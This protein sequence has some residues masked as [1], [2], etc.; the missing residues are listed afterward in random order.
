M[1]ILG[2][3]LGG[4]ILFV[5]GFFLFV[6]VYV[7][8]VNVPIGEAEFDPQA[9]ENRIQLPDGFSL[10]IFAAELP[11]ARVI[12]FTQ[13]GDL[14]VANPNLGKIMLVGRDSNNDGRSEGKRLLLEDLNGPNGLDFYQGYLYVA[15]TDAIGRVPFDHET[16]ELTGKYEHIVTGLPGG[17]RHWKKSLRF[18]PD[19]RMYVVMG[20]SCN[21][22]I[23]KDQR[24]A[25][26]T[27]YLADGSDEQIFA[28]GL[29]NSP[30]FD[31]SPVDGHLYAADNGTDMLGDDY[32]PCELNKVVEGGHYGWPFANG[33]GDPDPDF[34]EDNPELVANAIPMLHGFRAHNSPLGLEFVRQA[35]FPPDY[36]GAAIVALHGSWNRT[37]KDGYKVVSLHW[38][39]DGSIEERDLI[40]GFEV[41]G[42]VIGRPVEVTEGPDGAFYISDDYAGIVYRL[43]YGERQSLAVSAVDASLYDAEASLSDYSETQLSE[44]EAEGEAVFAQNACNSCH[45]K[46]LPGMKLLVDIGE[47]YDVAGIKQFLTKPTAPMPIYPLNDR[48]KEAL[49]VYL[50][51]NK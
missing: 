6:R 22:C 21:A 49:A 40:S 30:G 29:R 19:D 27:S 44:L 1:K 7:G 25:A 3:I 8:G 43:A 24:S 48:Q 12:R 18:G 9:L 36:Q 31:W 32:P 45:A 5:I 47:K 10:G 13:S 16:G 41:D 2:Y 20:S 39:P 38:Q 35:N 14:L 23:E 17:G 26:I 34:G 33:A 4:I 11:N 46:D 15:E 51:R 50:I 42:D 37:K 28:Q